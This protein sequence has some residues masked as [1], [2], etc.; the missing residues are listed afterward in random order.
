[1]EAHPPR[2]QRGAGEENQ[3]DKTGEEDGRRSSIRSSPKKIQK[4]KSA[5]PNRQN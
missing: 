1:M 4:K 3:P 5:F 2:N